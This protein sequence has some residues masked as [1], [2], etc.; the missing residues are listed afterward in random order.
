MQRKAKAVEKVQHTGVCEHFESVFNT[1]SPQSAIQRDL[2]Q[3]LRT[4][5]YKNSLPIPK[6]LVHRPIDQKLR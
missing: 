2:E 5:S 3:V 4:D 1:A 6:L